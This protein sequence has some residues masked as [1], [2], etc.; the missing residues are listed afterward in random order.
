MWKDAADTQEGRQLAGVAAVVDFS[1]SRFP[2]KVC[3][4]PAFYQ[5][6][7]TAGN[8]GPRFV[9]RPISNVATKIPAASALP[10][11]RGRQT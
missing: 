5:P 11:T 8:H 3:L 2:E 9:D 10:L 6:A 4:L 7:A 1:M